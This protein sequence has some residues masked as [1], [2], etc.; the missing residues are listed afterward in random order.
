MSEVVDQSV[1]TTAVPAMEEEEEEEEEGVSFENLM[2]YILSLT[3]TFLR[4]CK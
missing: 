1:P 3:L 2:I 4:I